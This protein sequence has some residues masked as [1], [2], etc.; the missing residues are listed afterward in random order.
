LDVVGRK[1]K[2][3]KFSRSRNDSDCGEKRKEYGEEEEKVFERAMCPFGR[4]EEERNGM[5]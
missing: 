4:D 2:D 3:F 1:L 5:E